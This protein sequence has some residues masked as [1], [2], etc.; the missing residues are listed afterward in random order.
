[1]LRIACITLAAASLAGCAAEPPRYALGRNIRAA[2]QEA[3]TCRAE[4]SRAGYDNRP[5]S[6]AGAPEVLSRPGIRAITIGVSPRPGAP[7]EAWHCL[8]TPQGAL[9]SVSPGEAQARGDYLY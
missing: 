5:V 1:M 6:L 2:E 9:T 4:V 7:G 8:F 3:E